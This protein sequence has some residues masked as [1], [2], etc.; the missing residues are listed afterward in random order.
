[1]WQEIA[2]S[3]RAHFHDNIEVGYEHGNGI[4][5]QY[6]NDGAFVKPT[7]LDGATPPGFKARDALWIRFSIRPGESRQVSL[8]ANSR[9][10]T[11]GV[12]IAQIFVPLG[13]GDKTAWEVADAISSAFRATTVNNSVRFYTPYVSYQ[14]RSGKEW[15]INVIC[16]F[17]ADDVA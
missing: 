14:G 15:Q 3:I 4:P 16:P 10:R 12:A 17:Y 9:F 13:L 5:T 6:D 2:N 7:G 8:G 1:M 11:P